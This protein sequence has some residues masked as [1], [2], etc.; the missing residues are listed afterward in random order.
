MSELE[1]FIGST[2]TSERDVSENGKKTEDKKDD[3]KPEGKPLEDQQ[4]VT[5][6]AMTLRGRKLSYTTKVGRI[7][8]HD[9]GEQPK[10]KVGMFYTAYFRDGVSDLKN[11]PIVFFWNGGPGSSS[12]WLHLY[13]LAPRRV[14]FDNDPLF[15]TQNWTLGDNDLSI[16]D[17]ADMVFID[18]P[19]TGFT[20]MAPGEDL[21]QFQGVDADAK[22]NGDFVVEFL[23][24]E[25]RN[26]SPV[27]LF[28]ES[29]ASLRV[30]AVTDYLHSPLGP[31]FYP[32]G[33]VLLGSLMDVSGAT[34]GMGQNH[35]AVGLLPTYTATASYH[36]VLKGDREKLMAQAEDF[37]LNEYSVAL[38]KGARMSDNEQAR[39]AK[40]LSELMGISEEYIRQSNYKV[41]LWKFTKELLRDRRLVVGRL[42]S[43]FVGRDSEGRGEMF[44]DDPS[45]SRPF[46]AAT[47]SWNNYV[48][49]ELGWSPLDHE[50]YRTMTAYGVGWK[51]KA[52]EQAGIWTPQLET[53]SQLRNSMNR[54]PQL[55]VL[56]LSGIYDMGTPYFPAELTF[57]HMYLAEDRYANITKKRYESGHMI[58]LHEPSLAAI[59]QDMVEYL[60]TLRSGRKKSVASS[61]GAPAKKVAAKR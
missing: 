57:D 7:V 56:M 53:A 15:D 29:Y 33:V 39:L 9:D 10:P 20:R 43:R 24:R 50:K 2:S 46:S 51:A 3:K 16:I 11:R 4:F 1:S 17:V 52:A 13:S 37:A 14:L 42:D 19:N 58:Y 32:D 61:N 12:I 59:R 60:G 49:D 30:P 44:E 25:R 18:P 55:K 35:G 34:F 40:R 48:R 47:R 31:G 23:N 6:H 21:E 27:V 22:L 38:M 36:G 8:M 41:T 5:K 26:E 45:M 54:D 28:G